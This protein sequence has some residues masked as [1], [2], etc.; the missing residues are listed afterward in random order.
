MGQDK[1]VTY[2]IVNKGFYKKEDFYKLIYSMAGING[3]A[4]PIEDIEKA[5]S[6]FLTFTEDKVLEKTKY[7]EVLANNGVNSNIYINGV[8]VAEE[9]NFLFSYNITSLNSQ[10]KKALNRERTNVGRTAYTGRIKDILK[11]CCSDIVIKNWWK[12]CKSSVQVINMTNCH[13]MT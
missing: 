8:R 9:L 5:K 13:G 2:D 10:I 7:G 12:I 3:D 4:A 1:K 6:L 11:D